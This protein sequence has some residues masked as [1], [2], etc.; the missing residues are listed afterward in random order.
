[1][2]VEG[3]GAL[4]GHALAAARGTPWFLG[5]VALGGL[6][7]VFVGLTWAVGGWVPAAA[8]GLIASVGTFALWR[9]GSVQRDR[10]LRTRRELDILRLAEERGGR[11][12]ATEVATRLRISAD[13]ADRVLTS[14]IGDGTR[15]DAE[16]D[17]SGALVYV[18]KEMITPS[19]NEPVVRLRALAP[20]EEAPPGARAEAARPDERSVDFA[21]RPSR[22]VMPK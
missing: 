6:G 19:Q 20:Q 21:E 22:G 5:S 3:N 8:L 4:E 2:V 18:F 15:V 9:R 7:V 17:P 16:I 11:L 14:L 13:D 12:A 1:M 10:A